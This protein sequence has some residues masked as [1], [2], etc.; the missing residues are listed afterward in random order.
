MPVMSVVFTVGKK[1]KGRNRHIVTDT[2]GNMLHVKV[3]AA[4]QHDT[5]AGCDVA[6]R[7]VE[8][9]PSIDGISGDAGYR[10]T[11]V[12]FVENKL[13]KTVE[14][15]HKIK[16]DFAI[17]PKRWVFERTFAW[18]GT[19]RRLAK[20]YEIRNHMAENFCRIALIRIQLDR[21]T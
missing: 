2:M 13:R 7:V 8:K 4:N 3:H 15:S 17:L 11:F 21:G 20:D 6:K 19:S 1:I 18:L 5:K 14:I 10:G 16:D 9:F 12:E